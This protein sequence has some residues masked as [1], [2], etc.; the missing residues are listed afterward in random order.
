MEDFVDEWLKRRDKAV[1]PNK[2]F[3]KKLSKLNE[4]KVN[5]VADEIH[6]LVFEKVDCLACA[7]C[8]KSIPP[9]VNETDAKRI[10]KFLGLK[11][12]VFK[13]EYLKMDEDGDM[14]MNQSPCPFLEEDNKC[15]IY[16]VRP[17]ACRE[18]PHTNNYEFFKNKKLH[19]INSKY[20]PG[21]FYI[22]EELKQYFIKL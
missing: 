12:T 10:S 11:V 5:P 21:V 2:K 9:I 20:C 1:Q 18:Y 16:E 14:V 17:R 15:R 13:E 3:I 4:K 6:D 19:A 8:C 22:L 7:N